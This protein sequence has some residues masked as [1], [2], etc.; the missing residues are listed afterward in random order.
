[1]SEDILLRYFS[2]PMKVSGYVWKSPYF[3][4]LI[5]AREV[6]GRD[7]FSG[8]KI[9]EKAHGCWLGAL[10]YMALVDHI[11]GLI[12]KKRVSRDNNDFLSALKSFTNLN[13]KERK[14]LYALRCSFAHNYHLYNNEAKDK[15]KIHHF[16][17]TS[18]LENNQLIT[19]PKTQWS[20]L[21]G[22][23]YKKDSNKTTVNIEL[24]ADLV[25]GMHLNILDDIKKNKII[26]LNKNLIETFIC[27]RKSA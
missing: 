7:I 15:S 23:R 17:V 25:E 21:H 19:F 22:A 8:K 18:G 27:Y 10:G 3:A 16:M 4:A 20:G 26:V 13:E 2:F 6:T 11:G 24:F 5:D 1:M 12:R 9:N 14:V